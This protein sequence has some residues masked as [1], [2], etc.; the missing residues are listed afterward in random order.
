VREYYYTLREVG[1]HLG[2]GFSTIRVIAKKAD[3]ARQIQK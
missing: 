1:D 2:L 3:E